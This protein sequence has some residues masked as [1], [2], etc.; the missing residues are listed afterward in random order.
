MSNFQPLGID[1]AVVLIPT[2]PLF[3][4]SLL[5]LLIAIAMFSYYFLLLLPEKKE[6][7]KIFAAEEAQASTP[8]DLEEAQV[9]PDDQPSRSL[10]VVDPA[11]RTWS[12]TR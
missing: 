2:V 1:Y 6:W 12:T 7:E 11:R 4:F 10:V 5:L 9:H 3:L 8:P